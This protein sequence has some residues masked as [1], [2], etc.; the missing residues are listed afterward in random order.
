MIHLNAVIIFSFFYSTF[1]LFNT[2][3]HKMYIIDICFLILHFNLI[4]LSPF[5]IIF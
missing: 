3:L 1:I 2:K 4:N 5:K